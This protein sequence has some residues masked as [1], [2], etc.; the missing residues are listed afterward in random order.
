MCGRFVS[1]SSPKKLAEQFAVDEVAVTNDRPN[2]NVAPRAKVMI[3]RERSGDQ[4][5]AG[6]VLSRVRW[7]LVP[8]WAKDP[9]IGDRLINARAETVAEKP[10][11]RSAFAKRR[12]IIPVDGFYEWKVVGPPSSPK[13]RP[14]KQPIYIHRR[15]D[16]PMAFAGLWETWKV[17]EGVDVPDNLADDAPD[18]WLRSCVIV[19]TSANALLTPVHDRMPVVLPASAWGQWLDPGEHDRDTLSALLSPAPDEW[20]EAYPVSTR[21][22]RVGNNDPALLTPVPAAPTP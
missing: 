1:T 12:C 17:P 18:G 13:G 9:G 11:F 19:T 6:R 2:Y 16:E 4:G 21:V 14:K 20:F 7:G 15:D 10:S 22:N 8:S 5:E 3:V